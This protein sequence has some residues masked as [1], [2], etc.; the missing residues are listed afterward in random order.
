MKRIDHIGIAVS[1]ISEAE[2]VFTDVLGSAPT[3][4]ESVADESVIVSFF[5]SGES[6][7][8]LLQSTNAEGPIARHI[9]KRG[10]GLHHVAF[11]VDDLDLELDRLKNLGYRV[12][13]GPKRGADKKMIA[14]LHP[15]DSN[16][17]LVELCAD[18]R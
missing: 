10:Q 18:Q 8:E 6:K 9:E 15:S 14:F 5:Q 1:N 7:V 2:K 4:R 11:H 16:K 17:V 3:K 12:V 13:S